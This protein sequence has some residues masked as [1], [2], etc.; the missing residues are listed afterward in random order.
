MRAKA[1]DDPEAMVALWLIGY[2]GGRQS[3][4]ICVCEI[5]GRDVGPA[6]TGVGV[7]VHPFDDP[8]LGDDFSRET[9][10]IDA[11]EFH[12]YTADWTPDGVTFSI[13]GEPI[14]TTDQSPSYPL[15]LMLGIYAFPA[16]GRK[17]ASRYP[18]EFVVD[19][20]RGYRLAAAVSGSDPKTRGSRRLAPK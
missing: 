1:T 4:E 3:A 8:D 5:F 16:T 20:V 9:V 2:E 13:D 11:R 10:A 7:G 15:Q 19:Y 18:K 6:E 12:V 17:A 14:K